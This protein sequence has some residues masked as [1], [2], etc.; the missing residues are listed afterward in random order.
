MKID[1]ET[2]FLSW[3]SHISDNYLDFIKRIYK[4]NYT[5][6]DEGDICGINWRNN[7]L[8]EEITQCCKNN[9]YEETLNNLPDSG[10]WIE[11][12]TNLYEINRIEPYIYSLLKPFESIFFAFN[13]IKTEEDSYVSN[14]LIEMATFGEPAVLE[15]ILDDISDF[16]DIDFCRIIPSF[17]INFISLLIEECN[18]LGYDVIAIA[19]YYHI[20]LPLCLGSFNIQKNLFKHDLYKGRRYFPYFDRRKINKGI[21]PQKHMQ[22]EIPQALIP[23]LERGK[24]TGLLDRNSQPI[25]GKMT[26]GQMK[27]FALY[28]GEEAGIEHRW[29]CFEILW[30]EKNLQQA[31]DPSENKRKV[32]NELFS[33]EIRQ[34]AQ[35]KTR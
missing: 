22:K 23:I 34:K 32:I 9:I 17:A 10:I 15:K 14:W 24:N 8:V 33:D 7:I 27:I 5:D 28:A 35:I 6:Y 18:L 2:P 1:L 30:N 16:D 25:K 21:T 29:K 12:K 13:S 19:E 3:Y 20:H 4:Y 31:S 11:I 26:K